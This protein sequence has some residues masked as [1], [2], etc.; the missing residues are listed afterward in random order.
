M[1][2][3][4]FAH[5][6]CRPPMNLR[7]YTIAV[8]LLAVVAGGLPVDA[9][10]APKIPKVGLFTPSTPVAAAPLVDA[11][12]QGLR[13]LGYIE[14]KTFV[15]EVRYGEAKPERL[16][17]L[18]RD[19][20]ALKVDVIVVS[21]DGAIAAVRRETGTI[22]IVM[23]NSSDPVG[24]GF[25]ASLPHPGGDVTGISNISPELSGKRL[26]L[27][28]QV[29]PELS[30]VAFFWNPEVRGNLLDYKETERAASSLHL[31]LQ[32]VEV[33][34]AE[35]LDRGFSAVTAQRA[36]ALILPAGNA[37]MLSKRT[38]IASFAQRN[39]LPA[40]YPSNDYMDA[41]GLMSYGPT[42]SAMYH[43]AAI[44]A[45]KIL[46]GAKPANLPVER[47]T[48]FEL[49]INLKTAKALGL[50]VPDSLLA[51]ADEVIE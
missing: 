37:V 42:V 50:T 2:D 44:Y 19:L 8:L 23:T 9:Q 39:R 48:K 29:V 38:E 6:R 7:P 12:K 46:K 11:F 22:P 5:A 49:V 34:S 14:G 30:R 47:P 35:D 21:T 13:E 17:E 27:L 32:S 31:E 36:Q 26:E 1:A 4:E 41:G 43:R 28:R 20:V 3:K 40:M 18:A 51:R 16:R 45:D 25:V 24:T 15:L 10:Q 33:S